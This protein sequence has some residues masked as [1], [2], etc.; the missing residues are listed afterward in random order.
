[1]TSAWPTSQVVDSWTIV[2]CRAVPAVEL[3]GRIPAA[4]GLRRGNQLHCLQ[5]RTKMLPRGCT[6]RMKQLRVGARVRAAEQRWRQRSTRKTGDESRLRRRLRRGA[7]VNLS[8]FDLNLLRSLDVLLAERNVTRAAE[9]LHVTQQ[10]ASGALQRLRTHFEDELLTRVGRQLELTALARSLLVPVRNAFWFSQ[11]VRAAI[12]MPTG[13][14]AEKKFGGGSAEAL[15]TSRSDSRTL[16][17][18]LRRTRQD[19]K[20]S[21]CRS[22]MAYC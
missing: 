19:L 7:I 8:H 15:V 20:T 4:W 12:R 13:R 10:A 2:G 16:G 9:R 1:M 17:R 18:T 14:M 21:R 6:R 22:W 5:A 11:G 3:R